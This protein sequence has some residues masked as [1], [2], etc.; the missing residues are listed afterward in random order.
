[1]NIIMCS[2]N[3]LPKFLQVLYGKLD[4]AKQITT[5]KLTKY[6]TY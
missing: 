6:F 1:M 5:G 3:T 2:P 4:I